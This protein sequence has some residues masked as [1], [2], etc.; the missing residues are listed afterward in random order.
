MNKKCPLFAP[1]FKEDGLNAQMRMGS[2][3]RKEKTDKLFNVARSWA[4]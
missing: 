4:R 2:I 1:H 3:A